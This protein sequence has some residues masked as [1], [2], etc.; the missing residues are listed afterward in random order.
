MGTGYRQPN[1]DMLKSP[2][3]MVQIITSNSGVSEIISKLLSFNWADPVGELMSNNTDYIISIKRY[4]FNVDSAVKTTTGVVPSTTSTLN[5]GSNTINLDRSVYK[6]NV[7]ILTLPP[8]TITIYGNNAEDWQNRSPYTSIDLYLP[9][10]GFVSLDP[11]LVMGETLTIRYSVDMISDSATVNIYKDIDTVETLI[12]THYCKIGWGYPLT[13]EDWAST[14]Q[15]LLETGSAIVGGVTNGIV[16]GGISEGIG[17]AIVGGVTSAME[18]GY[19][20][21]RA[22]A[23]NIARGSVGG[24]QSTMTAPASVYAIVHTSVFTD[25]TGL[26]AECGRPLMRWNF[27]GGYTT[28]SFI[29]VGQIHLTGFPRATRHEIDQIQNLLL[30]G[31]IL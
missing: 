26:N 23:P 17:G 27:I 3:N 2:A 5:F 29:K 9:Y 16:S 30:Q 14:T 25:D 7:S 6:A 28:G 21:I 31:V 15:N 4:P 20:I 22:S 24:N 13:G 12:Q 1:S 8:V 18:G 10:V 19:N 11:N